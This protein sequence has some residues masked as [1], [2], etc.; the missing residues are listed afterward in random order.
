MPNTEC[1]VE[2]YLRTL[3]DHFDNELAK[4]IMN[5]GRSWTPQDKPCLY[6]RGEPQQCFSNAFDLA[7][8]DFDLV[9]VEGYAYNIIPVSHAW[10][11]DQDGNVI[12]TTWED[13]A[14]CI[15]FGIPFDTKY[16]I[17]STFK[18]E[19]YGLLDD[20]RNGWPLEKGEHGG[21]ENW[22]HERFR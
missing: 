13:P 3:G 22:L 11:V 18:T 19:Y 17:Q 7:T 21:P 5:N 1:P 15:Y 16:L 9:Y 4:F 12:D 6:E 2:T 14:N 20:W 8:R 10:V